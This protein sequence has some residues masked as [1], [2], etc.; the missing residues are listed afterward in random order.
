M[1]ERLEGFE[2]ELVEAARRRSVARRTALGVLR[3]GGGRPVGSLL[4]AAVL[5]LGV[6]GTAGAGTLLALRDDV[7][8]APA[9]RD[10]P[11]EQ[12]P[13]RGSSRLA[14]VTA[15][16]PE[17]DALPWTVRVARSRTGL[18][19]STAGRRRG[20]DFGLVGLDDRFRRLPVRV[21]DGCGILRRNA[22]SLVGARVF[23]ADEPGDVRTVV[24]GVAGATLRSA[25]IEAGGQR[26]PVPV[27]RGGTFV[28]ALRGYPEDLGVRVTLRFADGHAE[29]H[30]FGV[31]EFVVPDPAGGRAWR[32]ESFA[33]GVRPGEPPNPRVCARFAP[34]RR[35]RNGPSSPPACGELGV[36]RQRGYFAAIRRLKPGAGGTDFLT[37]GN[38][39]DHPPRTAVWGT[40]GQ[41]VRSVTVVGPGRERRELDIA[42]SRAFLAVYGPEVDPRALRLVVRFRD[43]RTETRRRS[44][45]L[46]DG[47]TP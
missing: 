33:F 47:P 10:V 19:C 41:D 21:T 3:R 25:A 8:G 13:A 38:W 34:A 36:R 7:I 15:P 26:Q 9:A 40:A 43:G 14:S 12:M 6:A 27:G 35:L 2:R 31:S 44:A 32:V 39:R 4:L 23:D 22:T 18:L 46:V 45:N 37:T 17:R 11:A 1:S 20:A 30:P 42:P 5:G 29:R 16:D 24:N 28:A